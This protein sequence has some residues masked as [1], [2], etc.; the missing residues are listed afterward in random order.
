MSLKIH[1]RV[2]RGSAEEDQTLLCDSIWRPKEAATTEGE[3]IH[4]F[5]REEE[6]EPSLLGIKGILIQL[7]RQY[8]I[9]Q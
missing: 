9:G 7:Y 8:N 2:T 4:D 1:K 6:R 3:I 5:K